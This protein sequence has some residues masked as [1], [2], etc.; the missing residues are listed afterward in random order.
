M[1]LNTKAT[2]QALESRV[3]ATGFFKRVNTHE[4]KNAPDTGLSAALFVSSVGPDPT[5]SGLAATSAVVVYTLRL[6]LGMLN[7]PQDDIDLS[8][9]V[10]LDQIFTDLS[11]DFD[12]GGNARN[13]DLLGATGTGG[14]NAT[15]GYVT[16]DTTMY[17]VMDITVPIVHNDVWTQTA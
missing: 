3:L 16:V 13:I 10:A 11:S 8:V 9:V 14:L 2:I 17:R 6:Y 5:A 7:E 1:A 4:P 15:A 12:L